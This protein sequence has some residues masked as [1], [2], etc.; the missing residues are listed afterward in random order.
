MLHSDLKF[1]K[2]SSYIKLG[3]I[4]K[5]WLYLAII[6]KIYIYTQEYTMHLNFPQ[7]NLPFSKVYFHFLKFLGTLYHIIWVD[8]SLPCSEDKL[9]VW[10]QNHTTLLNPFWTGTLFFTFSTTNKHLWNTDWMH[11]VM[12]LCIKNVYLVSK[13]TIILGLR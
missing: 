12:R 2:K 11:E 9:W 10:K 1:L 3:W 5:G 4:V 8:E 7:T 13:A 6:C